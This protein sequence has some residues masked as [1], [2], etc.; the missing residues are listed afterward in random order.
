MLTEIVSRSFHYTAL[1]YEK[2][3]SAEYTALLWNVCKIHCVKETTNVDW[4]V[5]NK[6]GHNQLKAVA[7]TWLSF[8]NNI[9]ISWR[10]TNGEPLPTC[11]DFVGGIR[12]WR[13]PNGVPRDDSKAV[14]SVWLKVTQREVNVGLISFGFVWTR[15]PFGLI[16]G[17][18]CK[19]NVVLDLTS[20]WAEINGPNPGPSCS[21]RG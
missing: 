1:F 11:E 13:S 3:R 12:R 20:S 10:W 4:T 18:T 17:R 19:Q 16:T 21:K 7:C 8:Q 5:K 15:L 9:N 6:T 2:G 14:T